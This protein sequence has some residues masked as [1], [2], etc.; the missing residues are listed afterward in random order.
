MLYPYGVIFVGHA[1]AAA[2][3]FR[4]SCS[5]RWSRGR[6]HAGRGWRGRAVW[7]GWRCSSSIRS[8]SR[9][10]SSR[11]TRRRATV[12]PALLDRRRAARVGPGGV[13]HR[14]VRPPLG[15]SVRGTSRTSVGGAAQ[16]GP[17]VSGS[18]LPSPWVVGAVLFSPGIGL[19]AF[20]PFL[21]VGLVGAAVWS[22]AAARRR[23]PRYW[24]S[25]WPWLRSSAAHPHG[26]PAGAS[27]RATSPSSP[28]SCA[29]GIARWWRTARRHPPLALGDHRG[30]VIPSVLLNVTS[31][32]IYPHYPE[33]FDNPL[34]DLTFPLLGDGFL[35]Y[36]VGWLIGLPGLCVAGA[37]GCRRRG[38]AGAGHRGR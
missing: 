22:R 38:G 21:V 32:A 36:S 28:R 4:G 34:F 24:R 6:T 13:P 35:P 9:R 30:L 14:A 37:P 25:S 2:L 5:L 18:R 27:A 33:Q 10:R 7:S 8:P 29:D 31:G 3:A 19:F 15:L 16:S 17:P 20:S 26:T 12:A 11:R 1:L 23:G